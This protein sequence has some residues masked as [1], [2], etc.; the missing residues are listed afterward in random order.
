MTEE[1]LDRLFG[2]REDGLI[3]PEGL[4]MWSVATQKTFK[5]PGF[6]EGLRYWI[7][8]ND[9]KPSENVSIVKE[10]E[11]SYLT[12]N[13]DATQSDTTGIISVRFTYKNI[14]PGQAVVVI[15][16]WAGSQDFTVKLEQR[17]LAGLHLVSSGFGPA[18]YTAKNDQ[19][20]NTSVT[21]PVY[22]VRYSDN[23]YY[24]I[25][26]VVTILIHNPEADIK[27]DNL[28]IGFLNARLQ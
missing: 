9:K 2:T 23:G 13:K 26:F 24:N 4:T 19:E 1:E 20:W 10:G 12:A 28:R 17:D 18:L 11:N 16:D 5:N 22:P 15:Y 8:L 14:V 25:N 3:I 27:L 7:S 6:T 21:K